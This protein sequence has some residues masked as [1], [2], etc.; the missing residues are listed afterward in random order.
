MIDKPS[1]DQM[2]SENPDAPWIDRDEVESTEN[3][4]V[5]DDDPRTKHWFNR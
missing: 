3:S 4:N 2:L 1:R 5:V